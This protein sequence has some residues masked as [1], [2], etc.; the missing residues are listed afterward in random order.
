MCPQGQSAQASQAPHTT[1]FCSGGINTPRMLFGI[2]ELRYI[3][4]HKTTAETGLVIGD[5]L[6]RCIG[7]SSMKCYGA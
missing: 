1:Y 5:N 3:K 4:P 7:N 2:V 6:R